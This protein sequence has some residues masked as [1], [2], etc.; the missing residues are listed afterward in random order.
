MKADAEA[1]T[2]SL[3]YKNLIADSE[4]IVESTI[5]ILAMKADAEAQTNSLCYKNLIADS[6]KI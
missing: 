5:K 4:I 6:E 3:C 2:N 1:Q